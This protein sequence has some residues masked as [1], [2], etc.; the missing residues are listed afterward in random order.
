[1]EMWKGWKCSM[2]RSKRRQSSRK[3]P[4]KYDTSFKSWVNQQ[5]H[6][7]LP[8]LLPG[9]VYEQTLNVETDRSMVRADKVFRVL[10]CGEEHILHL[11]FETGL[12]TQLPARLLVYNSGLYRDYQLP[13]ITIVIYPFSVQQAVSPLRIMSNKKEILRFSFQTLPLFTLE[14]EQFVQ[15]HRACMYP[16]L[17]TM[18]GVHAEL[19]AQAMQELAELYRED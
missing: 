16:V 19:L 8:L 5:A 9:V 1:M 11:E 15:E 4:Q 12:D 17:P 13:V 10:Y 2:P 3:R 18:Q 6:E 7:I 14:A